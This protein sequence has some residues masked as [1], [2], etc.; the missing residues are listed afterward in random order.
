[1][2]GKLYALPDSPPH[3]ISEATFR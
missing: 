2:I 3:C 1:M